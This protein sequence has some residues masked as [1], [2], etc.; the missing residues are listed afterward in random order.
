MY[1]SSHSSDKQYFSSQKIDENVVFL[2]T[3]HYKSVLTRR[4]L[5][6]VVTRN[7]TLSGYRNCIRAHHKWLIELSEFN[8]HE[9]TIISGLN[10]LGL[11]ITVIEFGLDSTK[12]TWNSSVVGG[13]I[14]GKW[15]PNMVM[16][17][18]ENKSKENIL[19]KGTKGNSCVL[20]LSA[21][22]DWNS[23]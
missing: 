22:W 19:R 23:E 7:E 4:E 13:N 10:F 3:T 14:K 9:L 17:L 8:V 2:A 16:T 5:P 18:N 6:C 20:A 1:F 11:T 12:L 15:F 21:L